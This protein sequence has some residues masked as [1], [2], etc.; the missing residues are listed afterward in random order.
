MK[1]KLPDASII[2]EALSSDGVIPPYDDWLKKSIEGIA[3]LIKADPLRYR[4]YGPYWFTIKRLLNDQGHFQGDH[5]EGELSGLYEADHLNLAAGMMHSN[6]RML[7][8]QK[9]LNVFTMQTD[10]EEFFEYVL[11]DVDME[12][13]AINL[14]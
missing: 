6:G 5:F 8:G 4:S 9:T 2:E 1:Y 10:S 14:G 13:K 11:E 3:S 7:E 12:G